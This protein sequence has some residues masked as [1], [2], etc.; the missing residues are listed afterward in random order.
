MITVAVQ[1]LA[2]GTT[3]HYRLSASNAAGTSYGQDTTFTTAGV[4]SP[5]AQP[6]TPPLLATPDIAFPEET[7]T[8]AKPKPKALTRAQKFARA[9][10]ACNKDKNEQQARAVQEAAPSAT[11]PGR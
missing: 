11:S 9:L 4:L 3:Y 7:G 6:L 2:P 10:K 8:A 5:I 1:D